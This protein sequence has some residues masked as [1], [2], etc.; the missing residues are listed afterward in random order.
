[1]S[2]FER[3]VLKMQ[4]ES[5]QAAGSAEAPAHQM[6][7]DSPRGQQILKA[8]ADKLGT[9]PDDLK[10]QLNA[11]KSLK[12]LAAAK[13]LTP[14]DLF[15]AVR[16][17]VGG[18]VEAKGT[19][20][21]QGHHHHH[22]GGNHVDSQV[23]DAVSQKLGMTTADLTKELQSGKGLM[24]IAKEKGVSEDDLVSTLQQAFSKVAPYGQGTTA[25]TSSWSQGVTQV[26]A[27]V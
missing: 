6:N 3:L 11:G 23:L 7:F 22:R 16:Q 25:G 13:G 14:K 27:A 5:S 9:T 19:Q 1:M 21:A 17:A 15:A 26:N 2:D 10:A 24:D 18:S 20:G 8:L 12:D 4:V